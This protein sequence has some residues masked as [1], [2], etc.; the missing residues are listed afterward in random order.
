MAKKQQVIFTNL[1]KNVNE[2]KMLPG[3]DLKNPFFSAAL[4]I[5]ALCAFPEDREASYEM[6]NFLKG[7][8]PL[9]PMEK[10][11]IRDRFMDGKDYIPRSYFAGATPDNNY[12]PSKPYI[13]NVEDNPYSYKQDG[14]VTLWVKS[15][16]AD[17]A[18]E[19]QLRNKPSTGEWFVWTFPGIL[20]GIRMPKAQDPW[21]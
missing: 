11:F 7:P 4:L 15:G 2:L 17:T 18:R 1:P 10:Q 6:I 5:A 20:A 3:G 16:G 8:Q 21:A 14:Y 13:I 12:D 9:S 19:I